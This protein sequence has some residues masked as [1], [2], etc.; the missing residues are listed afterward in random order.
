MIAVSG[1]SYTYRQPNA[2]VPALAGVSFV[3]PKGSSCA[4]IGPS[5]CG[6]TTLLYI[7]AGLLTPESG[8]V[9]IAG[10]PP[11]AGRRTSL[12][13]QD[14]GLLPW[15]TVWDNVRLGLEVRREPRERQEQKVR[16]VLDFLGLAGLERHYPAQLS[17]GQRQRV[18]IARS[19]ATDPDLLLM[20]EPLSSLDALTREELQDTIADVLGRG[21]LSFVLVT[22]S[23]EE[24]VYLGRRILVMSGPP[25]RIVEAIDN[26]RAGQRSYR[27]T[28]EFHAQC[29]HV[30]GLLARIVRPER[31]VT[32]TTGP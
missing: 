30:R 6:K 32:E 14:Y 5:G 2:T 9:L 24:A 20:D 19:L 18:A 10:R 13:L 17:G 3:L 26:S 28:R 16:E 27:E 31:P 29:D 7:L 8:S 23:I 25:G 15:K 12:I 11:A 1:V 22:H 21:G 4:V